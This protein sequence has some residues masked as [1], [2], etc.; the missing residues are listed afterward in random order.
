MVQHEIK[1]PGTELTIYGMGYPRSS[2]KPLD[3]S[4]SEPK[5]HVYLENLDNY[6]LVLHHYHGSEN[7]EK[8]TYHNGNTDPKGFGHIGFIVTDVEKAVEEAEKK[9][10]AIKRKAGPFQDAGGKQQSS[11]AIRAFPG[12]VLDNLNRRGFYLPMVFLPPHQ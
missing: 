12:K 7:D 5:P 4:A 2:V 1:E 3:A 11:R 10:I 6:V 8:L 9:G